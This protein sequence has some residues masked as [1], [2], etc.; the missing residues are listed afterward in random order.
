RDIIILG[1]TYAKN[2]RGTL[3][4]N[5]GTLT[6]QGGEN[7]L[8]V[9]ISR[10]KKKVYVMT[11]FE[12]EDLNV[13]NSKNA[14]P[15]LFRKYLEYVRAVDQQDL[16]QARVILDSVMEN[17]MQTTRMYEQY[18]NGDNI[19]RLMRELTKK[20]YA[21]K[22]KVG[23]SKYGFDLVV[24]DEAKQKYILGIEFDE[25][26]YQIFTNARERDIFNHRFL[27][28]RGWNVL[29]IWSKDLA[30]NMTH[31]VNM[32]EEAIQK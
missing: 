13:Q 19:Q 18:I 11:S 10:A 26:P 9:A 14:G 27:N 17:K 30:E 28:T 24:Y 12:P 3:S 2:Q 23:T 25:T 8:N 15:K 22:E 7:R 1:T 6:H 16:E 29:R 4:T 21:V 31:V 20:G 32:I 5:F